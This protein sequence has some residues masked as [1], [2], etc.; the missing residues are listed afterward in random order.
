MAYTPI[1]GGQPVS[2]PSPLS[3][4]KGQSWSVGCPEPPLV[5]PL[6]RPR[7]PRLLTWIDDA[8]SLRPEDKALGRR[9][10]KGPLLG[11]GSVRC[12]RPR[13]SAPLPRPPLSPPPPL[14]PAP[15][16]LCFGFSC[17]SH[18]L[19]PPCAGVPTRRRPSPPPPPQAGPS[20]SAGDRCAAPRPRGAGSPAPP[21]PTRPP[22]A[23]CHAA[24]PA[25][26]AE[27]GSLLGTGPG[28]PWLF[29]AAV[30]LL[31]GSHHPAGGHVG[32]G[33]DLRQGVRE[34]RGRLRR[35]QRAVPLPR[36]RRL[37]LLLHGRQGSAQ[38]PVGD[39]G[40]QPRRGAG[41]GLRR[42][43]AARRAARGQPERHAAARLR[44]HGV[45]A[46]ARRSAVRAGR[47]RRHLQRLPGVR[48]R[49]RR[50]RR[51]CA[52][53]RASGAALGLL[54]G[55]H[56]QP[57]GLG[58]WPRAAPPAAGLRHRAGQH[59]W[60]LRRG[61]RRVPLPPARRLLLLLHAGQ[62]AA[63]DAVGEAD[64]EPRRGAG[65]DLRRRRL[66]APRDAEPER[67]AGAAARRRRLAAQPR[68]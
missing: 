63:Q 68:P 10:R 25:G 38:E 21:K 57:G 58:R 54:G 24:A 1:T 2:C 3:P 4:H 61:G 42:A 28:W 47:T 43:A 37:L 33:G 16:L 48:R 19:T 27:P 56:A 8:C 13:C 52:R 46:A 15:A 62:A 41:A 59:R 35:G 44:R 17:P 34:H 49:R 39:A 31:G 9:V 55:A 12:P 26:L 67:D 32:D 14:L 45:A 60:R 65:H 11:A 53:G 50:R 29:R 5:W 22:P 30:S 20:R 6:Q 23:R 64:E 18:S 7:F 36:A 40:A 51:A 66:E